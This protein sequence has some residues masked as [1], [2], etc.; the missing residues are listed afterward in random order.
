MFFFFFQTCGIEELTIQGLRTHL[1]FT[2]LSFTVNYFFN[3]CTCV[4]VVFA[5]V[6][7][8]CAVY[9]LNMIQ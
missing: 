9:I 4:Y 1:N 6:F 3:M 2:C 8:S 5:L 7:S